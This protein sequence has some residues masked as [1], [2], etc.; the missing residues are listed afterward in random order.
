[1]IQNLFDSAPTWAGVIRDGTVEDITYTHTAWADCDG[2]NTEYE[3]SAF[4][5]TLKPV[6]Q[7]PW[8]EYWPEGVEISDLKGALEFLRGLGFEK[9]VGDGWSEGW[10]EVWIILQSDVD[11]EAKSWRKVLGYER[12]FVG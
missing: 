8:I 6:Y 9:R 10:Y 5:I 3:P 7:A 1:M 4:Q 12:I 11:M 2:P